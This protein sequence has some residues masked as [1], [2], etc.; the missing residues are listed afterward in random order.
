MKRVVLSSAVLVLALGCQ[1]PPDRTALRP[2]PDEAQPL[3]YAELLT[4]ARLQASAA[5]EAFYVSRWDDLEQAASG[6]EQ[7]ARFLTK[8]VE[9]PGKHK[10]TVA[11]EST[12]LA[13]EAAKLRE[14]AK[15]Q[16]VKETNDIL[17]RV[18]LMVR[19]LRVD[20]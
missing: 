13:A 17:Q 5:T 10:A 16:N 18:N 12:D 15:G 3:P 4:R 14:A 19:Q 20:D 9:V 1:V 6:L 7:S 2:L 11:T 8:A